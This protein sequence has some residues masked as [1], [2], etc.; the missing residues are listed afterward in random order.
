[1]STLTVVCGA[2]MLTV[3]LGELVAIVVIVTRRLP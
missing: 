1:M 3:I 2:A